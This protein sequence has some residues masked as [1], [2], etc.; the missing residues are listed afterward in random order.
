LILSLLNDDLS[1]EDAFIYNVELNSKMVTN[2]SVVEG[3]GS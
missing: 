3:L 2:G 1:T